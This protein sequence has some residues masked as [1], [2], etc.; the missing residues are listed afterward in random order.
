MLTLVTR[1]LHT[2]IVRGES[3]EISNPHWFKKNIRSFFLSIKKPII[4]TLN[5][6]EALAFD[7]SFKKPAFD[8]IIYFLDCLPFK[9][10]I[11]QSNFLQDSLKSL[12]HIVDESTVEKFSEVSIRAF[13]IRL[14]IHFI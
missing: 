6:K 7:F 12:A 1:V 2:S 8:L 4:E 9:V 10:I 5:D 14:L 13:F 11:E 3:F